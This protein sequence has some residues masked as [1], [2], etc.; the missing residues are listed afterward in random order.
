[1]SLLILK[2]LKA[3]QVIFIVASCLYRYECVCCFLGCFY[4]F[5][6]WFHRF[7]VRIWN[8]VIW[9]L[10]CYEWNHSKI[11][12][13]VMF[14]RCI[15]LVILWVVSEEKIAR[16]LY[17]S[18]KKDANFVD[19]IRVISFSSGLPLRKFMVLYSLFI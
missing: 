10:C 9:L 1:M 2:I 15:V 16:V 8:F 18:I 11:D 4:F 5:K 7:Q 3:E 19:T 13:A 12:K 17:D 6:A 14:S